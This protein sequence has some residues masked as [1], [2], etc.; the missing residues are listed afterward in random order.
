MFDQVGEDLQDA[1][2]AA[3][4]TQLSAVEVTPAN[5]DA[6]TRELGLQR[7][8]GR[9][10]SQ[11]SDLEAFVPAQPNSSHEW[12]ELDRAWRGVGNA[13]KRLVRL[14]MQIQIILQSPAVRA[15]IGEIA[16]LAPFAVTLAERAPGLEL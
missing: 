16:V 6:G 10:R 8:V 9:N 3:V 4:E 12:C 2:R 1:A 15:V 13:E 14:G 7:H 11:P 5:R